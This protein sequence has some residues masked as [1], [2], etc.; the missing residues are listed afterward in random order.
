MSTSSD[1]SSETLLPGQ[2]YY[3]LLYDLALEK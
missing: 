2:K 3:R 1:H